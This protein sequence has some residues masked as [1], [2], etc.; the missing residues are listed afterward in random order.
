MRTL[1]VDGER[2]VVIPNGVDLKRFDPENTVSDRPAWGI[3]DNATVAGFLGRLQMDEKR[4]DIFFSALTRMPEDSRPY[5]VVGGSGP[6]AALVLDC[7]RRD[8]WLIEHV[9][10]VGHVSDPP[11]FIAGIDYLVLSSSSEGLPNV[12]L[13]S[14]AMRKPVVAT[15]VSDVPELVLGAGFI[16]TPLDPDSLAAG[17]W[18]VQQLPTEKRVEL[19]MVGRSRVEANYD[20]EVTASRFWQAHAELVQAV[21]S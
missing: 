8:P 16:A 10:L 15:S 2:I 12:V 17:I 21:A 6:D 4:L 19:G 14:M 9:R 3:P 20:L 1:G 13:E 5:V 7:I 18:A 11:A